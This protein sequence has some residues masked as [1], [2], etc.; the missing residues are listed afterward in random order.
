MSF[1]RVELAAA[2]SGMKPKEPKLEALCQT[3]RRE[4]K[5]GGDASYFG[6]RSAVES[7]PLLA[8]LVGAHTEVI[9]VLVVSKSANTQ[10]LT[11]TF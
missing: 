6:A 5:Q 2:I 7:Y 10:N 8:K 9:Q 1:P 11:T 3:R 4:A